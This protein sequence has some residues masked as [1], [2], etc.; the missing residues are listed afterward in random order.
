MSEPAPSETIIIGD[1]YLK[2]RIVDMGDQ[3]T[4]QVLEQ[5]FKGNDFNRQ[6]GIKEYEYAPDN[7]SG[8]YLNV[9]RSSNGVLIASI[10]SPSYGRSIRHEVLYVRGVD[11]FCDLNTFHALKDEMDLEKTCLA[12]TEYNT[13]M[14]W[15]KSG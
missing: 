13:L 4:L 11:G 6:L 12:I 9:F 10:E 15:R 8:Q 7:L 14:K 5:E 3:Y 2:L 1:R